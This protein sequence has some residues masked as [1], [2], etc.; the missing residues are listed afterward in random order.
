MLVIDQVDD[1]KV[2]NP[3]PKVGRA[4]DRSGAGR[5]GLER[6]LEDGLSEPNRFI[7]SE[8]RELADG[9]SGK[10]DSVLMAGHSVEPYA[11]LCSAASFAKTSSAEIPPFWS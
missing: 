4:D 11:A 10:L 1:S 5:S 9:R 8:P 7:G 6:E 3:D 2:A